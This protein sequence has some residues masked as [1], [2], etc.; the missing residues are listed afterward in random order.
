LNSKPDIYKNQNNSK[1]SEEICENDS[2]QPI[3]QGSKKFQSNPSSQNV[4]ANAGSSGHLQ[5]S[6]LDFS[7]KIS[8]FIHPYTPKPTLDDSS[9]NKILQNYL[10]TNKQNSQNSTYPYF[11][12]HATSL[13]TDKYMDPSKLIIPDM[14][15]AF[16]LIIEKSPHSQPTNLAQPMAPLAPAA[17]PPKWASKISYPAKTKPLPLKTFKKKILLH[18]GPVPGLHFY[19]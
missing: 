9:R 7:R 6:T 17:W 4:L 19:F 14:S 12:K 1:V 16:R 5:I 11:Q 15:K 3:S 13:L 10:A 18:P 2:R 8:S